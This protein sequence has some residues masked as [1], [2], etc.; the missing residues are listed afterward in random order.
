MVFGDITRDLADDSLP[1]ML[2]FLLN[3]AF[4][5]FGMEVTLVM[6]ALL[7]VRRMD[8]WSMIYMAW[9]L[10]LFFGNTKFKRNA[11]PY[12]KLSTFVLTLLQYM[13]AVKLPLF[14]CEPSTVCCVRD[15]PHS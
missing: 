7:V 9:L 13:L 2:K 15:I 14:L 3:F 4:Y 10:A 12:F 5:K 6:T 1:N 8:L 11:L